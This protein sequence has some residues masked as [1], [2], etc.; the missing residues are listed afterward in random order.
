MT[1]VTKRLARPVCLL[2]ACNSITF[3][4]KF[5]RLALLIR[6]NWKMK[7]KSRSTKSL[8]KEL[9]GGEHSNSTWKPRTS[10]VCKIRGVWCL[11]LRGP[12]VI[13]APLSLHPWAGTGSPVYVTQVSWL[14]FP[15]AIQPLGQWVTQKKSFFLPPFSEWE[16]NAP[17]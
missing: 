7:V 8:G 10:K 14:H 2:L 12:T 3:Y 4:G 15:E 16:W 13:N 1:C 11:M 17:R 9:L 6:F 5:L